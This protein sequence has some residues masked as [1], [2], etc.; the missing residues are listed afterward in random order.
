MTPIDDDV[1]LSETQIEFLKYKFRTE[2][3]D[4]AIDQLI[5]IL[6]VEGID[7][8]KMGAYVDKMIERYQC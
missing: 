4:E 5:E 7:P 8:I 1:M 6:V 2:D 3:A